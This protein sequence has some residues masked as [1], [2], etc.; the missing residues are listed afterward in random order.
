[1]ATG[2]PRF[3]RKAGCEQPIL[4]AIAEDE[5]CL[6]HFLD[7]AYVQAVDALELCQQGKAIEATTLDSLLAGA[8]A[9]LK[10]LVETAADEKP[11]R[12]ERILELLLCVSN[13]HEYV[14]HH[15]ARLTSHA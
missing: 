5:L 8:H 11:E 6:D 15:P 7:H 4:T 14:T 2:A 9:T 3:C 13:V 12:Q 1:M 10:A